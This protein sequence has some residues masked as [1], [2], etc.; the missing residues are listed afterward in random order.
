[1]D[2]EGCLAEAS[3]EDVLRE[4][5]AATAQFRVLGNYKRSV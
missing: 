4:A 5:E 2:I 3:M 1:V